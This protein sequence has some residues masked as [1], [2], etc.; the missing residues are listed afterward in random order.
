MTASRGIQHLPADLVE[1]LHEPQYR[2]N[3]ARERENGPFVQRP[4]R[5]ATSAVLSRTTL[6]SGPAEDGRAA[7]RPALLIL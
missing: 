1:S 2:P 3:A 6:P 5:L 7:R 4:G